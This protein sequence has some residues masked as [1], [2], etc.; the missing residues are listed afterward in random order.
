MPRARGWLKARSPVLILR[1][2]LSRRRESLEFLDNPDRRAVVDLLR[3][4]T[5]VSAALDEWWSTAVASVLAWDDAETETEHAELVVNVC[6]LPKDGYV[7]AM[8]KIYLLLIHPDDFDE[9]R[10]VSSA[11]EDWVRDL[12][13]SG[14]IMTRDK[15]GAGIFEFA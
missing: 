15:F 10:A 5:E 13:P 7:T 4:D 9:K 8:R 3:Q 6:E 11:H 12:G 14:G 2:M 1:Q